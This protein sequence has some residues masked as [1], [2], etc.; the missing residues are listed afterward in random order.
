MKKVIALF[1]A[2]LLTAVPLAGCTGDD[3][4]VS[5]P[6]QEWYE[7][8][9]HDL[10]AQAEED[11]A[12]IAEIGALQEQLE[13]YH[14][15]GIDYEITTKLLNGKMAKKRRIGGWIHKRK[16]GDKEH[17][18]TEERRGILRSALTV[19]V[20]TGTR[21]HS[22]GLRATPNCPHCQKEE[23]EDEM[24]IFINCSNRRYEST[25]KKLFKEG[26]IEMI[27]EQM[28]DCFV[29]FGIMPRDMEY[30]KQI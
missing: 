27:A 13:Y 4:S 18:L 16:E 5:L 25:R 1:L 10:E 29:C 15:E 20:K 12:I 17:N 21:M 30:D 19:G 2:L 6:D 9:I 8:K 11:Q 22:R 26:E 7:N 14:E 3:D 23:V 24:H 28:Q